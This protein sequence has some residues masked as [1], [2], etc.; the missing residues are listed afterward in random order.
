MIGLMIRFLFWLIGYLTEP[1]PLGFYL[2]LWLVATSGM[3]W[4]SLRWRKEEHQHEE[5][6]DQL[7]Q[8]EAELLAA[9]SEND[10]LKELNAG[11]ASMALLIED[12]H[13]QIMNLQVHSDRQDKHMN[14][15]SDRLYLVNLQLSRYT[16]NDELNPE[17]IE[18][19][20]G[21]DEL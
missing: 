16:A 7:Q 6:E 9:E 4:F 19:I 3:L 8:T 10:E 1:L 12:L 14:L 5:T 18:D 21:L 20:G 15:L 11:Y 2:L 13:Q 17:W